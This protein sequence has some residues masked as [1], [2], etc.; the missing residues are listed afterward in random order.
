MRGARDVSPING[1]LSSKRASRDAAWLPEYLDDA[2]PAAAETFAFWKDKPDGERA[3][4]CRA[5]AAQIEANAKELASLLTAEQGK[6]P[7]AD[8]RGGC[9]L[10]G[11]SHLAR[12]VGG[13]NPE[14]VTFSAR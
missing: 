14:G 11:G 13:Y 4:A 5:S 3:E 8:S 9:P 6:A 12:T 1:A 7:L 10:S 2:G